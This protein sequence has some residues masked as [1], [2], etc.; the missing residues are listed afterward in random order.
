MGCVGGGGGIKVMLSSGEGYKWFSDH[1]SS[2]AGVCV[3]SQCD[4][5]AAKTSSEGGVEY[6]YK[7]RR[8]GL[9]KIEMGDM[10]P[11]ER[12]GHG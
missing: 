4:M 6:M 5:G 1:E 10:V 7:S 12:G 9:P 8:R 11:V 3:Y 2:R